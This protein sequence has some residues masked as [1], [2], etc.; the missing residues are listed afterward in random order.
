M[1]TSLQLPCAGVACEST[2][3]PSRLIC[4]G[5]MRTVNGSLD[6][7]EVQEKYGGSFKIPSMNWYVSTRPGRRCN[8]EAI[9]VNSVV[10]GSTAMRYRHALIIVLA[11]GTVRGL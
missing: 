11:S 3:K 8:R 5:Y 9:L 6:M 2:V 10:L 1:P 4:D 7:G